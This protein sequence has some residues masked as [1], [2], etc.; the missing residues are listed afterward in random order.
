MIFSHNVAFIIK[1]IVLLRFPI[2]SN[3]DFTHEIWMAG[4]QFVKLYFLTVILT[5]LEALNFDF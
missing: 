4:K 3:I 2:F 1:K 5:Q